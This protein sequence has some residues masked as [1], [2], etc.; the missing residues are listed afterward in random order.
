MAGIA[1]AA[2]VLLGGCSGGFFGDDAGQGGGGTS[3]NGQSGTSGDGPV[4]EDPS[5]DDPTTPDD[6]PIAES[7]SIPADFPAEIPLIDADV[8]FGLSLGDSWTVIFT[9]DDGEAAYTEQSAKLLAAG[10]VSN[11]DA[12][13]AEGS[14]G[15]YESDDYRLQMTSSSTNGEA[16]LFIGVQPK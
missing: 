16:T 8:T 10:F 1:L 5:T 14:A 7:E 11:G 4:A 2:S 3:G 6:S 15:S 9:V 12:R 13:S